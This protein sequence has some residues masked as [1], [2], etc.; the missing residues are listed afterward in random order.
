[1]AVTLRDVANAVNLSRA[2]V[3]FVLN[4]RRDIAI[5]EATRERVIQAAKE[6]G[7]HPNR[8][9]RALVSG[10]TN[11]IAIWMPLFT[12]HFYAKVFT[13]L[14]PYLAAKGY[15]IR[16]QNSQGHLNGREV[17]GSVDGI[18]SVDAVVNSDSIDPG[19]ISFVSIGA[20][21]DERFNC[22]KIDLKSGTSEAVEHLIHQ[23]AKRIAFATFH[24][25]V[26]H[27]SGREFAFNRTMLGH[28]LTPDIVSIEGDSAE[29]FASAFGAY[30]SKGGFPDAILAYRDSI[31]MNAIRYAKDR[32]VSVPEEMLVVGFN[33]SALCNSFI[34]RLSSVGIPIDI[35]CR[36]A[37][38]LLDHLIKS[39]SKEKVQIQLSSSLVVRE[40]ST[41]QR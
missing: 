24:D 5:P 37:A 13:S 38:D 39:K 12:D 7:Y 3:S 23:G 30:C 16:F 11:V 41:A 32:G 31:A 10:K 15:T 20:Y 8:A 34:P 6:L 28:G 2:T 19:E 26:D 9:A 1:M 21:A 29:E 33:N 22:I 40:S 18:I 35:M 14:E 25:R 17:V 36:Q 4:D 27:I